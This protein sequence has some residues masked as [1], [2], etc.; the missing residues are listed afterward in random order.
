MCLVVCWRPG[1]YS[2]PVSVYAQC[3]VIRSCASGLGVWRHRARCLRLQS[4]TVIGMY[5]CK[6][7]DSSVDPP[8]SPPWT[9]DRRQQSR[10]GKSSS[11]P[12]RSLG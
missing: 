3:D 11:L 8:P 5:V 12:I 9:N 7:G 2:G 10:P 6:I 1:F 4:R